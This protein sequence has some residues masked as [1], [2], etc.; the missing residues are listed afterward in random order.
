MENKTDN[1]VLSEV[2]LLSKL[3]QSVPPATYSASG[4]AVTWT[5]VSESHSVPVVFPEALNEQLQ[6]LVNDHYLRSMCN[7]LLPFYPSALRFPLT[8]Q[9]PTPMFPGAPT[10]AVRAACFRGLRFRVGHNSEHVFRRNNLV[11]ATSR[12]RRHYQ[13]R[14][15]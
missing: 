5:K 9:R 8:I 2:R 11:L 6:V 7:H 4:V 12:R 10:I 14:F 15:Q 1:I 13:H 3:L